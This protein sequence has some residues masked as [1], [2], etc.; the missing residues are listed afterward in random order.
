MPLKKKDD[1]LQHIVK[2]AISTYLPDS[3]ILQ[4]SEA[5]RYGEEKR[6]I[7]PKN[8]YDELERNNKHKQEVANFRARSQKTKLIKLAKLCTFGGILLGLMGYHWFKKDQVNLE[9]N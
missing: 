4:K 8:P 6:A 7:V 5:Y 3:I 1:K 9:K 2:T